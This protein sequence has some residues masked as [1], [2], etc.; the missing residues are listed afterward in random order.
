MDLLVDYLAGLNW[1]VILLA[2]A[3]SFVVSSVWYSKSAFGPVWM[4]VAGLKGK[5]IKNAEKMQVLMITSGLTVLLTTVAMAILIDALALKGFV[6]GAIFGVLIGGGFL[7][8]NNGM[9]KLFEQRP[10]L[11]FAITAVGDVVS[12]AV[13]GGVLAF[14]K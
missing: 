9:H 11:H 13:M 14:F 7:V 5:S 3:A 4:K 2:A 12:L 1:M 8:T 10:A 6:D